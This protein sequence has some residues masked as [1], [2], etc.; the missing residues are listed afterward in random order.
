[1]KYFIKQI[2]VNKNSISW[3][4][5]VIF[6]STKLYANTD[7]AVLTIE[8][9]P[10]QCVSIVQ[11]DDCYVDVTIKWHAQPVADYCVYSSQQTTAL[12]CWK[13]DRQGQLKK[14]FVANENIVFT[15]KR[16][17]SE[18]A[19]AEEVLEMAWVYKNNGRARASWRM[20]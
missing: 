3:L 10:Q 20:F 1:M 2:K 4:A 5:L 8:V 19:L 7:I 18:E 15:L 9:D 16:P 13:N 12:Q 11:G 14:E 17:P 6:F